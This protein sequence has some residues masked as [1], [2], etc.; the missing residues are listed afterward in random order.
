MKKKLETANDQMIKFN[1]RDN[2]EEKKKKKRYRLLWLLLLLIFFFV[3]LVIVLTLG[4]TQSW[5]SFTQK[6]EGEFDFENGIVMH[7][8]NIVVKDN[9]TFSL[10]KIEN[11]NISAVNESNVRFDDR[12]EVLNPNISAAQGSVNFFLRAKID[13][14][15]TKVGIENE[16]GSLKTIGLEELANA[17][18]E[19]RDALLDPI[20]N[21]DN[22]LNAIFEKTLSFGDGFVKGNNGWFY[23]T[24]SLD[25]WTSGSVNYDDMLAGTISSTSGTFELFEENANKV[26]VEVIPGATNHMETFPIK[27]CKITITINAC[28]AT[29]EAFD[30]WVNMN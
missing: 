25:A 27:S 16:D 4:F 26:I 17:L 1:Y 2:E 18:N 30:G 3:A 12:Y 14:S 13:Y 7:Y 10:L 28:E 11:G 8:Q 15:F 5:Y 23:Y 20:Y 6:M 29:E 21:K 22:V 19:E 24:K 9:S